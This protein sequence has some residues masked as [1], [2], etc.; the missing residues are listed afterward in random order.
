MYFCLAGRLPFDS[1][2]ADEIIRNIIDCHFDLDESPWDLISE[3]AK[4]LVCAFLQKD[5]KDRIKLT[6][7]MN[8]RWIKV[9][10]KIIYFI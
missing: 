10:L 4:D 7:A 5:P 9:C 2:F 1:E 8:H 6:E 3:D